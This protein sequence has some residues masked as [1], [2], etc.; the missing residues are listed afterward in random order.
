MDIFERKSSAR[1]NPPPFISFRVFD[2]AV[3]DPSQG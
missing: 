3:G 1:I 2:R